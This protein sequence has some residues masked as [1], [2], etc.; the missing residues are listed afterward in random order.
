MYIYVYIYKFEYQ[1]LCSKEIAVQSFPIPIV[2]NP[3]CNSL[4]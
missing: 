2:T 3:I 4:V 1:F